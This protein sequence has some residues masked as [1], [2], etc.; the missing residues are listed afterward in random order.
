MPGQPLTLVLTIC[1]STFSAPLSRASD[2][3]SIP[4][5]TTSADGYLSHGDWNTFN[6]KQVGLNY[7]T[8]ESAGSLSACFSAG[9]CVID[10][11][12]NLSTSA[13][14]TSELWYPCWRIDQ[15][16]SYTLAINGSF[17]G[18]KGCFSGF[19]P[20]QITFGN[21]AITTPEL[22]GADPHG[23]SDSTDAFAAWMAALGMHGMGE[24]NGHMRPSPP[25]SIPS[26]LR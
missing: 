1:P 5:A 14:V 20:G 25:S 8:P 2:T 15:T 7:S 18:S 4:Q 22:W 26:I 17:R 6:T 11:A 9:N 3:I 13:T 10:S 23:V 24:I 19:S 16:G 21:N 12:Q